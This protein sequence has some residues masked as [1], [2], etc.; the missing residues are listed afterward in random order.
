VAFLVFIY[1]LGVPPPIGWLVGLWALLVAYLVALDYQRWR[2]AMHANEL[3]LQVR[4][5]LTPHK[6]P[7]D[8]SYSAPPPLKPEE[9]R[10]AAASDTAIASELAAT[11]DAVDENS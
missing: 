1:A 7:R 3:A 5:I 11:P 2:I 6:K 8:V 10:A 9:K 4:R